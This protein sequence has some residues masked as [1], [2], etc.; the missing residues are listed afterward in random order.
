MQPALA[1][2]LEFEM[3]DRVGDK[4]GRAFEPRFHNRAVEHATGR[5]D[6][7][8]AGKVFVIAGL[9]A[10]KHDFRSR[11]SLAGNHLGGIPV[12]RA[13]RAPGFRLTQFGKGPDFRGRHYRRLSSKKLMRLVEKV[14][15]AWIYLFLA[16]E[17]HQSESL[18]TNGPGPD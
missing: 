17:R 10:D 9:L 16:C 14:N 18:G 1:A 2:R 5:S 12:E 11:R 3:L 7:R 6:E 4:N 15:A 8:P 13:A